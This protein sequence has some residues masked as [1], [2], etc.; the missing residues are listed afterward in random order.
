VIAAWALWPLSGAAAAGVWDAR[1][2]RIP[3]PLSAAIAAGAPLALWLG[4]WPAA[5][6]P[7]GPGVFLALEGVVAMGGADMGGGDTALFGALGC[8][9]GPGVL[10]LIGLAEAVSL[11][12][13]A[14]RWLTGQGWPRQLRLGP[15]VAAAAWAAAAVAGTVAVVMR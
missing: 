15:S 5:A 3:W 8:W 1:T 7:W 4:R 12:R 6:L 10:A 13:G 11:L 14:A 2:G 9:A